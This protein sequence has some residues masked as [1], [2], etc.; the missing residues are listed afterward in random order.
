MATDSIVGGGVL[1]SCSKFDRKEA[2]SMAG[3]N[4][5]PIDVI[6]AK[7][8]SHKTKAEIAERRAEELAPIGSG[9]VPPPQ[10]TAKQK[11]RFMALA[12][13]LGEW[14]VMSATDC[15]ALARYVGAVDEYWACVKILRKKDVRADVEI[16]GEWADRLDKWDKMC[17]RLEAK[18]GLT[19]VDR[20]KL[21]APVKT[22]E[23]KVN[24][25]A[26]FSVTSK[27]SGDD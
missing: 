18:L 4:K 10:L 14:K 17:A 8:K 21:S 20:A 7:G 23:P 1:F 13:M 19:P 11:K 6:L 9:I 12:D 3:R 24:R 5:E 15:E 16:Y 25:F 27:A 26:K 2:Q 22:E